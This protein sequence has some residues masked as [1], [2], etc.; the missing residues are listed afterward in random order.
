M[1]TNCVS[2]FNLMVLFFPA[3]IAHVIHQPQPEVFHAIEHGRKGRRVCKGRD[4]MNH[5]NAAHQCS[6]SLLPES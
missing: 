3:Y 5:I 2:E 1:K 4:G 6:S